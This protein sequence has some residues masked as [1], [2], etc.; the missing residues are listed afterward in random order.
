MIYIVFLNKDY[1]LFEPIFTPNMK[2]C[3]CYYT[4]LTD[5]SL[6]M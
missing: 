4:K 5:S 6:T 2:T 1:K 3:S